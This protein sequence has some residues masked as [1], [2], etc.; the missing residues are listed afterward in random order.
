[1]IKLQ[2]SFCCLICLFSAGEEVYNSG[3][4][5]NCKISSC[6]I[7]FG[8]VSVVAMVTQAMSSNLKKSSTIDNSVTRHFMK[9][10]WAMLEM[11]DI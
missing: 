6:I 4:S 3:N 5:D 8:E 2:N 9:N 11:Y 1:M 10:K 7:S